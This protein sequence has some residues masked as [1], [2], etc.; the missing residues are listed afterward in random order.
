MP[1]FVDLP[2]GTQKVATHVWDATAN[3][4]AGGWVKMTQPGGAGGGVIVAQVFSR[5]LMGVGI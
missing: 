2:S 4:G 5:M 3:A 1:G